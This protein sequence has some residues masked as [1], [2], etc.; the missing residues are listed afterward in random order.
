MDGLPNIYS[1]ICNIMSEMGAIS[2]SKRN[3][4]QGFNYRGVDD[5]MNTLQPLLCAHKVFVVPEVVSQTREERQT[6]G[7]SNLI[8]SVC[9]IK[10]TFYAD[11]GSSVSA[12]V[13]GEGMDSG[14]KSTNKAMSV[15]FKY[16]C[17]QVFCIPTEEMH[18]PDGE[19]HDTRP[20]SPP[21]QAPKSAQETPGRNE[22]LPADATQGTLTEA[23]IKRLY[24]KAKN[25]NLNMDAAKDRMFD[26]YKKTDFATLTK[27]EYEETCKSL[28]DYAAQQQ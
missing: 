2:K 28:D 7:G 5:V 26:V 13:I 24:A 16:A 15:A 17:F 9:T 8:Y 22:R 12:V 14:D 19:S 4:S 20:K 23:Q 21:Q 27:A 10:Y 11:D 1:A 18:D 25:A 3:Q 6:K